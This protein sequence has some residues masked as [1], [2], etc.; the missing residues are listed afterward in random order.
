MT[1][2]GAEEKQGENILN[3]TEMKMIVKHQVSAQNAAPTKPPPSTVK[4]RT[5]GYIPSENTGTTS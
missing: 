3:H 5:G 4:A 2:L 1:K